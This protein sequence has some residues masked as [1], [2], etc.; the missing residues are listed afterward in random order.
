MGLEAFTGKVSDL[1]ETNPPGTDPKSQGDDHIRG[2]KKT[3]IGQSVATQFGQNTNPAHNFCTDT[4][5]DGTMRFGRGNAFAMSQAIW[6]V[7]AAGKVTFPQGINVPEASELNLSC[8]PESGAF[9]GGALAY[10]FELVTGN[11][12]TLVIAWDIPDPG[13]GAGAVII[14]YNAAARGLVPIGDRYWAIGAGRSANGQMLQVVMGNGFIS[15]F[16]YQN[17]SAVAPGY[18]HRGS[19]E[20]ITA[21][22]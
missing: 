21:G 6:Q 10:V 13:T 18:G 4:N 1:V 14:G 17:G 19:L 3:I 5:D 11:Q 20:F 16:D 7:D 9:G 12:V 2:I 15:V 8:T 22:R